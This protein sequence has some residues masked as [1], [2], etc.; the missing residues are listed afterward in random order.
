MLS[1]DDSE[2][3]PLTGASNAALMNKSFVE[4]EEQLRGDIAA[5]PEEQKTKPVLNWPNTM[6]CG[7]SAPMR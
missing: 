7:A 2:L 4:A 5:A 3:S 6:L 1:Q